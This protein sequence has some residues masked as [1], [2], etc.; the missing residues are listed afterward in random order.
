MDKTF[1]RDSTNWCKSV[2]AIDASQPYLFSV[3]QVMPTGPYTRWELDLESGKHKLRQNKARS[4][5][6]VVMSYFQR[7]RLQCRN[8]SFYTTGLQK[9]TRRVHRKN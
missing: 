3:C 4:F 5:E 9:S 6:N 8:E 2:I 1:T 7:V